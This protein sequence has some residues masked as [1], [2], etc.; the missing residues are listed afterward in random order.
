MYTLPHGV[1]AEA[2]LLVSIRCYGC[3]VTCNY[4]DY[5]YFP[6]SY[7]TFCLHYCLVI[8]G[9]VDPLVTYARHAAATAWHSAKPTLRV[10]HCTNS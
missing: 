5:A 3:A 6:D 4:N 8:A 7:Y 1:F 10:Q 9:I 2:A